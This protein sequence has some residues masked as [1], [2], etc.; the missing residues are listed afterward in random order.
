MNRIKHEYDLFEKFPN[1]S[2]LWRG[3]FQGFET[4][5]LRL[6]ELA[7]KSENQFYAISLTTGE[8]VAFNSERNAR[9]FLAPVKTERRSKSQAA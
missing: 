5:F 9:E 6:K 8:V 7:Q 3:S 4:T 1:G 2:S